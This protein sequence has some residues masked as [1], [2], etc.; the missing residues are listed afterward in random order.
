M[1]GLIGTWMVTSCLTVMIV[2]FFLSS[3]QLGYQVAFPVCLYIMHRSMIALK[4]GTLSPSEYRYNIAQFL[5][6]LTLI[7]EVYASLTA[8]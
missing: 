5:K 8:K 4:Y 1:Q 2:S 6:G 7:P 3:D